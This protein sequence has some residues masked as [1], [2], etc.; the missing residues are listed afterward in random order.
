MNTNKVEGMAECCGHHH[1]KKSL[2]FGLGVLVVGLMLQNQYSVP[3]ILVVIGS[4][5]IVKSI[6]MMV[7]KK[8]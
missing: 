7:F 2:M 1:S 5:L 4:I 3:D 6:L 8:E